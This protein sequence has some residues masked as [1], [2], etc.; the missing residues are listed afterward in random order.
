MGTDP[1]RPVV[2]VL[3]RMDPRLFDPVRSVADVVLAASVEAAPAA[4]RDRC[5]VVVLRSEC[6]LRLPSLDLLPRLTDVV[7]PGSGTDNIDLVELRRRG[8]SLHCNPDASAG[9]VAE[10]ALAAL[11]LLC[12]QVPLGHALL[13]SGVHDKHRLMG[14]PVTALNLTVWGAGPVGRA[15]A[16]RAV[17][18]GLETRFVAHPSVPAD[19]PQAERAVALRE[20]DA[21]VIAL[22]LRDSTVGVVD[23]AWLRQAA[24]RRPYLVDVSRF[25]ICVLSAVE[26]ALSAGALRGFFLDPVDAEHAEQVRRLLE[27]VGDRNVLVSQHQGAQRSD[28]RAELN[29]WAVSR[30]HAALTRDT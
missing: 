28:I 8:I 25:G 29:H 30:V 3:T 1:T 7:R 5:R 24:D 26:E 21:H 14:E 19:L 15:V 6:S 18:M 16:R 12:R 9:S 23:A 10:L 20:C 4:A 17:S 27:R 22:P 2:L 13:R 11:T